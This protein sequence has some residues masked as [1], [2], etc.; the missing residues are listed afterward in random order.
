MILDVYYLYIYFHALDAIYKS[1]LV[2]GSGLDTKEQE[3]ELK[4]IHEENL[5]MLSSMSKEEILKHQLELKSQ[6][7]KV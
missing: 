4:K 6:L 3:K 5:A 7:G 1:S 2:D